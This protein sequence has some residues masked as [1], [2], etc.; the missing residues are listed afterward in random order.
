MTISK[1]LSKSSRHFW[2][3]WIPFWVYSAVV[4]EGA[5]LPGTAVPAFFA[6]SVNDKLFHAGEYFLLFLLASNAF[7]KAKK[8]WLQNSPAGWAMIYCVLLGAG[9][10]AIQFVVP[11][12]FAELG[13]WMA[14]TAGALG[15][16]V[17]LKVMTSFLRVPVKES[18]RHGNF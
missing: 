14:D 7:R 9:T 1:T 2:L 4:F 17:C 16:L 3:G 8:A 13:D 11:G 10:E 18:G 15:G 6:S 5:I 12:R